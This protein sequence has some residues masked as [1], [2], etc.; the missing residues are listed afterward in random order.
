[1][2]GPS[3]GA[4]FQ[5]PEGGGFT[6]GGEVSAVAATDSYLWYGAYVDGLYDFGASETRLSIGPEFGYLI[7]GVDG[8]YLLAASA[9]GQRHGVSV[10]PL[11]TFGLVAA[12]SRLG[13]LFGDRGDT[14]GEAGVLLKLPLWY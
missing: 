11:L 8:G 3:A 14:F 6:L 9:E 7:F 1:M 5:H 2:V 4:S 10:R 12:Y 13:V